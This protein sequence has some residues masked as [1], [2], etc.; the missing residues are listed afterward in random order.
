MATIAISSFQ[1]ESGDLVQYVATMLAQR[2]GLANVTVL[3]QIPDLN[4]RAALAYQADV[5]LVLIGPRWVHLLTDPSQTVARQEV[6]ALLRNPAPRLLVPVLL[7]RA[8]MPTGETLPPDVQPIAYVQAM[9]VRDGSAFSSDMQAVITTIDGYFKRR[10]QA[11]RAQGNFVWFRIMT[12]SPFAVFV[13]AGIA[14]ST[15]QVGSA[16]NATPLQDALLL[17]LVLL[18]FLVPTAVWLV[19]CV[20]AIITRRVVW[21][22]ANGLMQPISL[23]LAILFSADI[24]R[25]PQSGTLPSAVVAGGTVVLFLFAWLI[26]PIIFALTLPPYRKK[27]GISGR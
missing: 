24:T 2:Y 8:T 25:L 1:P 12:L 15:L 6:S 19:S 5:V 16:A 23:F 9:T 18:L 26:W 20:I 22:V 10:E 17:V 21:A 7:H 4:Q 13:L 3:E 27:R 11:R 14:A